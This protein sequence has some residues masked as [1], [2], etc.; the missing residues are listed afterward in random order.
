MES[1]PWLIGRASIHPIHLETFPSLTIMMTIIDAHSHL[2]L[3]QDTTVDGLPVRTTNRGRSLFLGTEVQMLPPFLIDGRNSAE[4]FL[5]NMDYAQVSAAVVVQEVIDGL[6]NDYLEEV[7]TRYPDRFVC[8]GMVDFSRTDIV[9]QTTALIVRGFRALAIPAHRLH[10]PLT[11]PGMMQMF[12]HMEQQ[13]ILLS[14]CLADDARQIDEMRDVIS[15]CPDLKVAV[16]HFGMPTGNHWREQIRLAEAPNVSIESGGIT[17]LYNSEFY[18]Y[19]SAMRAIREAADTV[20][21]EHLMWGSDYP[22]TITAITYRMAYDF[23]LRSSLLN[24]DEKAAFLGTNAMR[25]YGIDNPVKLP[26]IRNMSE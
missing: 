14:I 16:G 19:P 5:S 20:G 6:Q 3:K 22:R 7:Q 4:V 11:N 15:E 24:D 18:P 12:H 10:I 8:C 26:Y 21:I 13:G 17:W 1:C 25:F 23:V 9:D 2:W